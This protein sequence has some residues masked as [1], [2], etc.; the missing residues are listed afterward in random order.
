MEVGMKKLANIKPKLF[1]NLLID[2][3]DRIRS[4]QTS[5]VLAVNAEMLRLY[6]DIGRLIDLRQ[7]AEGW[8]AAV[9]PRLATELKNELPEL[10]GF[11]ERNIKRM[12]AFY[13]T[14]PYPAVIVPQA[15][16]QLTPAAILPPS[17]AK[18]GKAKVQQAAAL[19]GTNSKV[20]PS[21]ALLLNK[22]IWTVP[23]SHQI[24]LM[25]KVKDLDVRAWYMQQTIENGWSRNILSLMIQSG[26]HLRQGKA[27]SNFERLLPSPQSDLIQQSLKDPYIFDFLTLQDTFHERE[28][29]LG[30]MS[31][32]QRFLLELGQG[33]SFV[34]RQVGLVV[35]ED[36]F[37]IDLLFYH[38]KLRCFVVIDLKRG[39]FKP[40]YA[41]KMNFYLS[42]VDDKLRHSSD[43]PSIGLILCQDRNQ[44][45]AE[46]SLR[47]TDAPI[48]ISEYDL[49]R[50]LPT[51]FVSSLPTVEQIEQELADLTDDDSVDSK[52][53]KSKPKPTVARISTKKAVNKATEKP[54]RLTKNA[55]KR[56]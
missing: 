25:E 24:I 22:F 48:G 43:N 53:P 29:E 47:R 40:E 14:Y 35:G 9:I 15:V 21:V 54:K 52:K 26:A 39:K 17:A 5:A 6:W 55:T 50:A 42:V 8:G 20:P 16:A 10:K 44:I 19:S 32:L 36:E 37:S 1:Q 12:L 45:I 56:K 51:D 28:L 34:G 18:N 41:G 27:I 13:R 49:T 31:H 7:S 30:L 38:L 33:F 3:R 4:S 46:Y 23:W 11:S 2:I